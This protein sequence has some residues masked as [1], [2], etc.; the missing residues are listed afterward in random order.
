MQHME[1]TAK[2]V[3]KLAVTKSLERVAENQNMPV[4]NVL[5]LPITGVPQS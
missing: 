2:A 1:G 5:T 4:Y 3:N